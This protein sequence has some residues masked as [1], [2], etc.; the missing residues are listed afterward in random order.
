MLER[1]HAT[2]H[3]RVQGVNFRAYTR[4]FARELGL[5]GWVRNRPEGTVETVAEGAPDM[6]MTFLEFLYEGSPSARV[7]RVEFTRTPIQDAEFTSFET[8]HE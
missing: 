3:G 5:V 8:H 4:L 6:I 7:D 1:L 2:V